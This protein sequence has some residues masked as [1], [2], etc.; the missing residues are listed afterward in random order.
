MAR[1]SKGDV[2]CQPVLADGGREGRA[3]GLAHRVDRRGG[4]AGGELAAR[5]RIQLAHGEL[6]DLAVPELGDEMVLDD[7]AVVRQRA[8]SQRPAAGLAL[9]RLHGEPPRQVVSESVVGDR[10]G[11]A[12]GARAVAWR[13]RPRPG[14]GCR[15][16]CRVG[17]VDR[18]HRYRGSPGR[19]PDRC[20]R[21]CSRYRAVRV[22]VP[23]PPGLLPSAT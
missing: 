9:R 17:C 10:V 13:S 23:L 16:S 11:Q 2:A 3:Q 8:P 22:R 4:V 14:T 18:G 1:P 5:E 7:H 19:A 6:P 15:R 20:G 12:A 21:G